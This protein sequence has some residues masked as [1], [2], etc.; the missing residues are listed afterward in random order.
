MMMN[1]LIHQEVGRIFFRLQVQAA[2]PEPETP[3]P[4]GHIEAGGFRPAAAT[5]TM[6]AQVP[7]AAMAM[8]AG[9]AGGPDLLA[10]ASQPR[11][12][13]TDPCPC[14]SGMLFRHCHGK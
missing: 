6:S 8:A 10:P 1:E 13:A 4:A 11:P 7:A 9:A 3:G 14:G 5:A 2:P 12:A